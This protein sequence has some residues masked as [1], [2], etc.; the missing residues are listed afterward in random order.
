MALIQPVHSSVSMPFWTQRYGYHEV[1]HVVLE[2]F[3]LHWI[4]RNGHVALGRG[5]NKDLCLNCYRLLI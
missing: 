2:C 3:Y 4:V 1:F 5:T